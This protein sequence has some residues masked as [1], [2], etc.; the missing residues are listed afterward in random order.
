MKS[1]P[2]RLV[3]L[4]RQP[5]RDAVRRLRKAYGL[6]RLKPKAA[7]GLPASKQKAQDTTYLIQEVT[8]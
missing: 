8:E 2:P 6:L 1:D 5:H 4:E 3:R 7:S